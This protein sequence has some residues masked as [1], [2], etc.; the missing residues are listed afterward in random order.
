MRANKI[1]LKYEEVVDKFDH[2]GAERRRRALE[3]HAA[4]IGQ[5]G[6][7]GPDPESPEPLAA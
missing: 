7:P 1:A 2:R 5:H 4:R 6:P 3:E